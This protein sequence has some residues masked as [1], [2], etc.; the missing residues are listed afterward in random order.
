MRRRRNPEII[1]GR[2]S[3]T[4]AIVAGD[5]FTVQKTA[6]GV[7]QVTFAANFRLLGVSVTQSAGA[8]VTQAATFSG[9]SFAA[10]VYS[11]GSAP[12]DYDFT[13]IAVGVQQ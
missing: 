6:V 10:V 11:M 4:G 12:T 1:A 8:G 7:Y 2:V 13:F 9:N 3:S 5:G